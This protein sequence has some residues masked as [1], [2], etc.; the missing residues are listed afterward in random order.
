M[1]SGRRS[2]ARRT[3]PRRPSPLQPAAG[4]LHFRGHIHMNTSATR[5]EAVAKFQSFSSSRTNLRRDQ[6]RTSASDRTDAR[7]L[8][9]K[10][11]PEAFSLLKLNRSKA[12]V[13]TVVC[14]CNYSSQ[15]IR[16][17]QCDTSGYC[18]PKP[19][20]STLAASM[21][22]SDYFNHNGHG[23]HSIRAARPRPA[24]YE[25]PAESPH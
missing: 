18:T 10:P 8:H 7:L 22:L 5:R 6:G 1:A 12:L 2:A 20:A 15:L 13:L 19:P 14:A 4:G 21:P 3:R 17:F 25:A 9:C 11:G 16:L 24:Y 23:Q